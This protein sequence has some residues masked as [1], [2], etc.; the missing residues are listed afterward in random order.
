MLAHSTLHKYDISLKNV[1][2]AILLFGT[3]MALIVKNKYYFNEALNCLFNVFVK[4]RKP[5]LRKGF[6]FLQ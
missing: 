3:Y 6:I 1:V 4:C 2:V 5:C